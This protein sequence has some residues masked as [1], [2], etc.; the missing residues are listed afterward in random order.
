MNKGYA[1]YCDADPCFYDAPHRAA[2]GPGSGRSRY[3]L[4][5]APVPAGWQRSESGDWLALRPV[6]A[7]L[8]DQGWKIHVSACLDN[9]ESV[10]ERVGRH[11][12]DGGTAFK[13]VPSRYLLHQ[14]N[15]KYADRAGS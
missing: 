2:A 10:L 15:A 11:C 12:L 3:A 9:A 4:A 1:V 13:F 14:R 8:P 6:D 7:D 5:S